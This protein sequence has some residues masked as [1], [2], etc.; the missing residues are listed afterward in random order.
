MKTRIYSLLALSILFLTLTSTSLKAQSGTY[1]DHSLRFC[2]ATSYQGWDMQDAIAGF[3]GTVSSGIYYNANITAYSGY[4]S[5]YIWFMYHGG[6]HII[7]SLNEGSKNE[8]G[9]L[10]TSGQQLIEVYVQASNAQSFASVS[11]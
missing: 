10:S 3:Y 5:G 1:C 9:T 8:S 11:W 6:S 7:Q 4:H 2:V